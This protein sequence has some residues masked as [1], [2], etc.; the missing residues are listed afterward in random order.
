MFYGANLAALFARNVDYWVIAALLTASDYGI[1]VVAYKL[2][3]GP[4]KQIVGT[5]NKVVY[6]NFGSV[7]DGSVFDA[8]IARYL[9]AG[10]ALAAT[11]GLAIFMAAPTIVSLVSGPD[12][13]RSANVLGALSVGTVG[14]VTIS[15]L[16]PLLKLVLASHMLLVR[17]LINFGIGLTLAFIGSRFG[18]MGVALG[19]AASNFVTGGLALAL[20]A[21]AYRTRRFMML[22][23]AFCG[24]SALGGAIAWLNWPSLA[25]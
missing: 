19:I 15:M 23:V 6:A 21:S 22:S 12:F 7:A 18:V 11:L 2:L 9:I 4:V 8:D 3:T 10:F 25:T 5:I 14:F 24:L 17:Q 20:F 13:A 16:D 1:Y